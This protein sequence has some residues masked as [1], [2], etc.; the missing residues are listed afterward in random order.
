MKKDKANFK[1]KPQQELFCQLF[2]RDTNFIGNATRSYMEAYDLSEDQ[3]E[4]A[5]RSASRLLTNVDIRRRVN[6]LLDECLDNKVVDRALASVILQ[7]KDLGAK[8]AAIREY[9]RLRDRAADKLEGHFVFSW[10]N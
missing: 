1:L 6:E 8:I 9:N 10:E 2:T 7:S 4:S 3:Y 5:I